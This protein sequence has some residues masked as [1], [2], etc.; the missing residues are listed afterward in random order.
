MIIEFYHKLGNNPHKIK[1]D[2]P[3]YYNYPLIIPGLKTKCAK[4]LLIISIC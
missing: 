4:I 3:N 1:F 2:H